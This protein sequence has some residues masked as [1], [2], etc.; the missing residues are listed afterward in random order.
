MR[1]YIGHDR[2]E[3]AAYDVAVESMNR[4][5]H[6][7][8]DVKPLC[9]DRLRMSGL[10]RRPVDSRGGVMYDIHSQ[11]PQA[12]E[13][14]VSRFL[15]PILEQK[16]WALFMD[17]DML[18]LD[19]IHSVMRHADPDCAVMVVKH[20]HQPTE[21]TK[22]DAQPQTSYNRKNWSSV[23]LWN[24][25]HPGNKRLTLDMVNNWP[26]RDLHAF[27]WLHDIEIGELPC[28]WNWLVGVQPKPSALHIA[29]YTLG[30]PWLPNWV[31]AE[32]DDLWLR[33][34]RK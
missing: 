16:G 1:V 27:A 34:V 25:D 19:N 23:I 31:P 6:R 29:H 32:H 7:P 8:V 20:K 4:R 9:A 33:E 2:R 28:G 14:A 10:L 3:Q 5:A 26:G 30:G 18:V 21:Q 13:F 22:M 12:T 15:V 11:A 17:C 24:C